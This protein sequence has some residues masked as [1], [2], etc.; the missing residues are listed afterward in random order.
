MPTRRQRKGR[1][2]THPT[3]EFDIPADTSNDESNGRAGR[4][5]DSDD[6]VDLSFRAK[7]RGQKSNTTARKKAKLVRKPT[8]AKAGG[9]EKSTISPTKLVTPLKRSPAQKSAAKS[10]LSQQPRPSHGSVITT[11]AKGNA[12]AKATYS[13]S[14][15]HRRDISGDKE[16]RPVDLSDAFS[17]GEGSLAEGGEDSL[18]LSIADVEKKKPSKEIAS[19]VKKFADVDEWE[20]EFEDVSL[21]GNSSPNRR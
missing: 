15:R 5:V 3:N 10:S 11:T 1:L 14:R 8:N 20:M 2:R 21:G 6:D 12:K 18:E 16:N 13:S 19:I 9:R 7:T 17:G 4:A